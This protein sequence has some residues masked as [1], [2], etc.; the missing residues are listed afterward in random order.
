MKSTLRIDF[1]N[2]LEPVIKVERI[3]SDDTRDR[4]LGIWVDRLQNSSIAQVNFISSTE[5][6]AQT[7]FI[8]TMGTKKELE[9]M[10]DLIQRQLD[11]YPE[12]TDVD[13]LTQN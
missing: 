1:D 5:N 12:P 10:R 3:N 7:L 9:D 11:T 2:K 4:L 6:G 8:K 13:I